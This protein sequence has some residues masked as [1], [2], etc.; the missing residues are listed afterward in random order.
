MN[1]QF[2]DRESL[3]LARRVL[4]LEAKAVA[5]LEAKIDQS[6]ATAIRILANIPGRVIVTGMGKS[7]LVG[8]KIAATLSSTGTPAIF[9]HPAEAV[10]GDLG[11]VGKR[12]A[13]ILVSKSGDTPELQS[14]LPYIKLMA[15]PVVGL[16][17]NLESALAESCDVV[18]DC[19]VE[20]EACP[21]DLAPTASTTATL[22]MGDA[23]AVALL[24]VKDFRRE[25]F[26]FLH[27]GGVLGRHLRER[28]ED[29]MVKG[30]DIP[31]VWKRTLLPEIIDEITR[32]KLGAACVLDDEN[33]LWGII[34]DGDLR[35]LM[36]KEVDLKR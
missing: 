2:N 24:K 23:L 4:Q 34:T 7:G 29:V 6:F 9:L 20:E 10:H 21:F 13:V 14:L 1:N 18:L 35:R 12:D 28:I 31:Q 26:A 27:P 25:D 17:G 11:M 36:G 5:N 8:R 15:V 19:S 32:K 22:A 30:D 16:L 3:E 33:K